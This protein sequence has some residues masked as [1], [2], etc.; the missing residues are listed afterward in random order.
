MDAGFRSKRRVFLLAAILLLAFSLRLAWALVVESGTRQS[1]V[2]DANF[3]DRVARWLLQGRGYLWHNGEPTAYFPPGYPLLLAAVYGVFG[4]SLVVA[5]LLNVVLGT[6][7]CLL[8]Y[9]IGRHAYGES[10]GLLAAALFAVFP[11]DIYGVSATLSEVPFACLLAGTLFAFMVWSRDPPRSCTWR[12]LSLGVMLG[13][14]TLIRGIALPFLAVFVAAWLP[15]TGLT[16]ETLKRTLLAVL[17]LALVVAPWALRN[18]LVMGG[19]ILLSTDGAYVLF[20]AHSP[21]ADGTQSFALNAFREEVFKEYRD[22]PR[23]EKEVAMSK[24]QV[25]YAVR[26]MLTHPLRELS[27]VPKRLYHLYRDDHWAFLW[28]GKVHQDPVSSKRRREAM[29][30]RWEARWTAIADVYFFV[31]LALSTLGFVM[32]LAPSRRRGVVVPL[33][34]AYFNIA[35]GIVFYGVPRFHAPFVPLL[36]ILAALAIVAPLVAWRSDSSPMS[37]HSRRAG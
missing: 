2:I 31:I 6:L 25:R 11:G 30:A 8:A 19:P 16:R 37:G 27:L 29:S 26:Y 5:K 1:Y 15:I 21:L 32:A 7:T 24:A 18:Q 14:A 20:N 22:L 28:L 33:S 9:A 10:V 36:S 23:A 35:H 3:Y 17:G 12:W 13:L 4:D 34:V